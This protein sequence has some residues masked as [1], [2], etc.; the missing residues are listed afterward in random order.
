[1]NILVAGLTGSGKNYT[2]GEGRR[3]CRYRACVRI[4]ASIRQFEVEAI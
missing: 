3:A 1:M 4:G 2:N